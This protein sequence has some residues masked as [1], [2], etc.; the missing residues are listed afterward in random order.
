MALLSAALVLA[1]FAILFVGMTTLVLAKSVETHGNQLVKFGR[2]LYGLPDDTSASA[3]HTPPAP[4]SSLA[5]VT[6]DPNATTAD[7]KTVEDL[8]RS[9]RVRPTPATTPAVAPTAPKR[10]DK[11]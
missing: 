11:P 3:A 1:A 7:S 6:V 2:A 9:D 10:T 5:P 4:P 8:L